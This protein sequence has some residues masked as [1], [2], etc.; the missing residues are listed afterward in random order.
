MPLSNL[1][2]VV[3]V[4]PRVDL[5]PVGDG[6]AVESADRNLHD[7]LVGEF[8]DNVRPA[9]VRVR[10]VS[11][12]EVVAFTPRPHFAVFRQRQRELCAALDLNHLLSV[13]RFDVLRQR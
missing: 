7:V 5:A 3:V 2:S 13:Q 11:E 12:P 6:D 4:S 8:F 10:P 9:N 1:L